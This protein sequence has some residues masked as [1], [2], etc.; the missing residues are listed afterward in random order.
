MLITWIVVAALCGLLV[1]Y[2]DRPADKA[3]IALCAA[4][5]VGWP[6]AAPVILAYAAISKRLGNY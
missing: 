3:D 1:W 4:I 2:V 6:V 5:C